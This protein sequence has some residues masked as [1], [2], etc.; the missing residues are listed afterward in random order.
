MCQ[1]FHCQVCGVLSTTTRGK[2]QLIIIRPACSGRQIVWQ[3]DYLCL[4]QVLSAVAIVTVLSE[5]LGK[6]TW[7]PIKISGVGDFCLT[8]TN[9]CLSLLAQLYSSLCSPNWLHPK[10][11]RLVRKERT[12][13]PC[14]YVPMLIPVF[15]LF[16]V[17]ASYNDRLKTKCCH[18]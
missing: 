14:G 2:K 18:L 1:W 8:S 9:T 3:A 5:K 7:C 15:L 17:V 16:W 13:S 10:R 4:N 6:L 11:L 12:R